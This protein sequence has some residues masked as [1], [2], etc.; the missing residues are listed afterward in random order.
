MNSLD[1]LVLK[2]AAI[3]F[4]IF[5]IIHFFV[6]RNVSAGGVLKWLVNTIALGAAAD[7]CL[8]ALGSANI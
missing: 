8:N 2:H 5:F 7:I 6:F 4:G 1:I 3:S